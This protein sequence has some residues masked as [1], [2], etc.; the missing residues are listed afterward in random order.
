MY[1]G[2]ARG[3]FAFQAIPDVLENQLDDI[4]RDLDGDGYWELVLEIGFA[5][6]ERAIASRPVVYQWTISAF[7]DASVRFPDFY[8]GVLRRVDGEIQA[9][10][11]RVVEAETNRQAGSPH[12]DVEA[13]QEALATQQMTRDRILWMLGVDRQAPLDRARNWTASSNSRLRRLATVLLSEIPDTNAKVLLEQ[14]SLDPD[15]TVA[16]VA[17]HSLEVWKTREARRE[18]PR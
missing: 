16:A 5:E 8:R 1:V 15:A 9:Q 12:P 6:G 18:W 11:Q 14:L 4:V 17:Q 3:Q 13:L 7:E 2:G 10:T